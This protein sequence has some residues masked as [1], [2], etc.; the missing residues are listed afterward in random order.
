[1]KIKSFLFALILLIASCAKLPI[2]S[3]NLIDAISTEGKRM[4]QINLSMANKM[5]NEKRERID[6]FIKNEYTPKFIEEFT[7]KIPAGTD[8]TNEMPNMMKSIIPKIME[9]RDAMQN[10]LEVNRIKVIEKLDQDYKE[11]ETACS[12]LKKLLES[13][14]KV[15]DERKKLL[16]KTQE[17]TGNKIDFDQI[18]SQ[19]DK[20]IL[21]AGDLGENINGLNDGVNKILNK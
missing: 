15:N 12:E 17:L 6:E 1:M 4:H 14:I 7:K 19:I 18:G 2:Q 20:F 5:F 10:A 13:A 8:L 3:L 11:Y 9:R 21:N 16:Q